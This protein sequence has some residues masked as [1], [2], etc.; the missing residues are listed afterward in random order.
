MPHQD[1]SPFIEFS[2]KGRVQQR[3]FDFINNKALQSDSVVVAGHLIYYDDYDQ[4]P[5]S[6]DFCR[7]LVKIGKVNLISNGTSVEMKPCEKYNDI[8]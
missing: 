5:Y 8:H 4:P 3:E 6:A 1:P 2:T 7:V